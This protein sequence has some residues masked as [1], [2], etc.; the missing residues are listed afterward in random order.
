MQ[1]GGTIYLILIQVASRAL[2][3][4][5]NQFVLRYLSPHLLGL[6]VQ[7]ELYSVSVLYFSR[8]S[9][10]V[11]LQ[12]HPSGHYDAEAS[13]RAHQKVKK[14]IQ[15]LRRSS[16]TQA[17]VNVAYL[18]ILLGI[19]LTIALGYLYHKSQRSNIQVQECLYFDLS[20]QLYALAT[21]IE[22]LSEPCFVIVQDRLLYQDRARAETLAAIAKCA[23]TCLATLLSSRRG[24]KASVLPFAIGQTAYAISLAG[25]YLVTVYPLSGKDGFSLFPRALKDRESTYLFSIFDRPLVS[26]SGALYAQSVFK[27]ILTQGDALIL[28]FFASLE[29][30]GVFAL[31]SNYG[32]LMARLIFQPIE[33]S[34]RNYFGKTLSG[35]GGSQEEKEAAKKEQLTSAAEYLGGLLHLYS[36]VAVLS[37]C[38]LYSILPLVVKL[39]VGPSWF[40]PEIEGILATYCYYI[41]FM[42]FNGI[43]DAFVTSVA[44]PGELHRQSLWMSAFT[45]GYLAA[46]YVLL[47]KMEL[48]ARGL[49]LANILNMLLR[50]SWGLR[51]TLH[52]LRSR[53]SD[54]NVA[55]ALLPQ[56]TTLAVGSVAAGILRSKY[57]D[58]ND[59]LRTIVNTMAV[60]AMSGS[61]MYV[62]LEKGL[63]C[64][65]LTC[66]VCSLSASFSCKAYG[67]FFQNASLLNSNPGEG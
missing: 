66:T 60:S 48:G 19:P 58:G 12:R 42:A 61:M 53:S 29:D 27:Q 62:S 26:L 10:R 24:L 25:G 40:T 1:A 43:L 47:T 55:W 15:G 38:L 64:T 37:S 32:G 34:S 57:I 23:T 31:A 9:L 30:Q 63:A 21:L 18:A 36:I 45:A 13:T 8:E 28:G 20:L 3:F 50:V 67:H 44:A 46:A 39:I 49:V 59:N 52:Y 17:I 41:P 35:A 5:G 54:A 11:A 56:P 22:L 4:A 7:L 51:F 65:Q 6:A 33:E 14:E 2:T 16:R